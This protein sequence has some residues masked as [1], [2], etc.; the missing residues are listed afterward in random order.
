MPNYNLV[1][2][3]FKALRAMPVGNFVAFPAE[4]IRNSYHLARNAWKDISGRT[5][6]EMGI[7]D[8]KSIKQLRTI[9]YKRLAGMTT[10]AIAGDAAVEQSKQI[11]GITDKQEDALNKTVADWEKG[12]NKIFLSPL[13]RN[14]KG[15]IEVDYMNLG[16]LDPYSYIKNPV[17]K[18]I[19]AAINNQ[20]YNEAELNDIYAS[21]LY[22]IISPF[23]SPSMVA[24]SALDAYRGKKS[25]A[26]EGVTPKIARVLYNSFTPGTVDFIKR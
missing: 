6:K 3:A 7:T 15:E 11:F 12:T 22:D 16:P 23:A 17:K 18:V 5:A 25:V 10:A 19:N 4:M 26:D 24:Q 2:K 20:D 14:D 13:K 8:E 1:P 9:G 21:A